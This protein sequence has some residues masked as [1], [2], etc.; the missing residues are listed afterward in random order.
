MKNIELEALDSN[1]SSRD[2]E[3]TDLDQKT[4]WSDSYTTDFEPNPSSR[5]MGGTAAF[6]RS[7]GGD[8]ST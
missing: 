7:P 4:T 3:T 6:P 2:S 1:R 8:F 5:Q